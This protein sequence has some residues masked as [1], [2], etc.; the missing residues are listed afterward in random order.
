MVTKTRWGFLFSCFIVVTIVLAGGS[1]YAGNGEPDH[2]KCYNVTED[3]LPRILKK[4]K[5]PIRTPVDLST[6]QFDSLDNRASRF[7]GIVI[8]SPLSLGVFRNW[9][10][11]TRRPVNL[12]MSIKSRL[13]CQGFRDENARP[14]EP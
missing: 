11:K 14:G 2:L 13:P 8:D 12:V 3:T 7:R 1:A 9:S 4:A 5:E 10:P 6:G